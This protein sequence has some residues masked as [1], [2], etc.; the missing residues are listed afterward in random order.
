MLNF[1]SFALCRKDG[2]CSTSRRLSD[3]LVVRRSVGDLRKS[4][5]CIDRSAGRETGDG[6]TQ[7][8]SFYLG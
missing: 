2:N 6:E 8:A 4:M 7:A 5:R 1:V 3:D